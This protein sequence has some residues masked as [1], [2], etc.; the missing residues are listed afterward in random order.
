MELET[1]DVGQG[2]TRIALRGR[3]DVPGVDAIETRFTALAAAAGKNALVDLSGVSF[4]ASMG[5]R[6]LIAA[7]RGMQLK[8]RK[9]VI[10]GP[11]ELVKEVLDNVNLGALIPIV[12]TE[13]SAL[14]ALVR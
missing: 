11:Q 8:Q 5:I 1:S 12:D 9:M 6:M 14:Q 2:A 3:L 7:A 13:Q 10:F 4:I